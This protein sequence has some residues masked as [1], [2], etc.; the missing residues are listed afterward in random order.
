MS[1]MYKH[2]IIQDM[3]AWNARDLTFIQMDVVLQNLE[4]TQKDMTRQKA[5]FGVQPTNPELDIQPTGKCKVWIREINQIAQV[6]LTR[7]EGHRIDTEIPI[8]PTNHATLP[9]VLDSTPLME[10]MLMY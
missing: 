8:S 7:T 9:Q 5:V 2:Q 6:K 4:T 1:P 10:N 3:I